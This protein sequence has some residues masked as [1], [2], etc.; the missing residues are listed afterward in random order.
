[1]SNHPIGENS[2]NL[3][4]LPADGVSVSEAYVVSRKRISADQKILFVGAVQSEDE[5]FW[6][7]LEILL[8]RLRGFT[9]RRVLLYREN[10][11]DFPPKFWREF[12]FQTFQIVVQGFQLADE[13]IA[14]PEMMVLI[15]ALVAWR[16]GHRIRL[17]NRRPGF[18]S[19]QGLRFI[20]KS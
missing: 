6:Q 1:V 2:S 18:G 19:R 15:N 17:R 13:V 7:L 3:V 9:G 8:A 12:R 5:I 20:R 4:T 10:V 14:D 11:A 16:S